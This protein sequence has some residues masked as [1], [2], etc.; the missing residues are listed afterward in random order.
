MAANR[1]SLDEIKRDLELYVGRR[2]KLRANRGRRK[3]I[4]AEG[5]LEQTYPKVFVVRLDKR[6][7]VTNRMSYSYADILT[8]TVEVTVDD[9]QIGV[10]NL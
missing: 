3:Y 9:K 10:A 7:G 1:K 4:E 5:V 8:S 6:G 2:V